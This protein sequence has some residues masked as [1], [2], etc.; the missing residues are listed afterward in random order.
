MAR[1]VWMH[2]MRRVRAHARRG[3]QHPLEAVLIA[4]QCRRRAA[5][6]RLQDRA[7]R[8]RA[9]SR[10]HLLV[11]EAHKHRD[12]AARGH[13]LCG[14]ALQGHQ[15]R[16]HARQI[17]LT[18]GRDELTLVAEE[19]RPLAGGQDQ[20]EGRD[21]RGVVQARRASHVLQHVAVRVIHR[22]HRMQVLLRIKLQ[23]ERVH[24]AIQVNSQLRDTRNRAS[25]RQNDLA[26]GQ[27]QAARQR[28]LAIQ[29]RVPHHAAVHLD[30]D[31]A[32]AVRRRR[33][34]RRLHR[35]RR[36]I[37]VR[38]HNAEAR[39]LGDRFGHE[40]RGHRATAHRHV[41]A[42]GCVPCAL[43]VDARKPSVDQA[44]SHDLGRVIG[45]GRI[46]KEM[47]IVHRV[48]MDLIQFKLC[49]TP[50]VGRSRAAMLV[51]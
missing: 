6:H 30:V 5:Q 35:K 41:A 18:R 31:L 22:P 1:V 17:I 34:H 44:L 45:G 3:C 20:V 4:P 49:H 37:R 16:V 25:T 27:N 19:T 32:P 36:R 15:A 43:L 23:A 7:G 8:A 13:T 28:Q 38:A 24:V 11:I 14:E 51:S 2:R 33:L 47:L 29:P 46:K 10:T 9:R 26:A 39:V 40:P 50:M 48:R 42:R 21:L 12:V